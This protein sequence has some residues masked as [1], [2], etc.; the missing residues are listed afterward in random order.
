MKFKDVPPGSPF[1]LGNDLCIRIRSR[2]GEPPTFSAMDSV[3]FLHTLAP[4]T[5]V[6]VPRHSL[7]AYLEKDRLVVVS[8]NG[9]NIE[10][11]DGQMIFSKKTR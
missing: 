11:C 7:R 4:E 2:D 8:I 1:F 6:A 10:I 5:E 9:T 3:G